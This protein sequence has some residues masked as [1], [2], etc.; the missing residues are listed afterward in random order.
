[1]GQAR[2][3]AQKGLGVGGGGGEKTGCVV[4]PEA[5]TRRHKVVRRRRADKTVSEQEA[6]QA[7][8]KEVEKEV[9]GMG[10]PLESGGLWTRE[11][12]WEDS[13]EI[14]RV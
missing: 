2:F 1:L 12:R 10:A 11:C 5:A 13:A 14:F 4:L 6:A 9:D 3:L 8:A 7:G